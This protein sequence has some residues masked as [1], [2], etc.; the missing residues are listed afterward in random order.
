MKNPQRCMLATHVHEMDH[1]INYEEVKVL[2]QE[3]NYTKR[4]FLEMY[5]I[6]RTE[7]VINKK[8]DTKELSVI[9]TLI[10]EMDQR[11]AESVDSLYEQAIT[12]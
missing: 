11:K 6:N 10:L 12:F 8:T 1:K 9:H 2:E 7:E 4:T 3:S 5:H